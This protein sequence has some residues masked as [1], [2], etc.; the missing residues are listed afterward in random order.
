M[1]A[2]SGLEPTQQSKFARIYAANRG[3]ATAFWKAVGQAFDRA[4]TTRLQVDGKLGFLTINNAP[5]MRKL[6][7]ASGERGLSD[8]LQL[9]QIGLYRASGWDLMLTPDVAVPN[10]IPGDS[11]GMRRRELSAFL[12]AQVRLSYPTAAVAHMVQSGSCCYRRAVR[13]NSEPSSR[14]PDAASRQIRDRRPTGR[15]DTLRRTN[16]Q[17]PDET[18]RQVERFERI[19]QITPSDQAMARTWPSAASTLP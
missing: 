14:I 12:A 11:Q 5:L 18:V 17:V 4:T 1:L 13:G 3:D 10:E 16:S 2:V 8:V 19:Y 6:H 7:A 15:S 9:A